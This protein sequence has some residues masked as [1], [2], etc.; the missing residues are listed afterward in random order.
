[1]SG[2]KVTLR[3][4]NIGALLKSAKVQAELKARADRIAA[5]AGEGMVASVR[6]GRNRA[7]A[8]VITA[9]QKAREN[10]ARNRALTR[11]LD[12]GR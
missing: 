11:A 5:A 3:N 6:V 2:F 7:R 4:A 9:T 10:E 8:S 1:M 12:A